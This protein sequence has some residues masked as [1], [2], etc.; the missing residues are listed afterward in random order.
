MFH[1]WDFFWPGFNLKN[2]QQF[3]FVYFTYSQNSLD[4][5]N[6]MKILNLTL[7]V[8]IYQ[9]FILFM[10]LLLF[11]IVTMDQFFEWLVCFKTMYS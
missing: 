8:D 10:E 5:S 9:G 6:V 11:Y 1:N 4:T 7:E 2:A 3:F